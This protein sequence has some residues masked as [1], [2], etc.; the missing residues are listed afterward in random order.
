MGAVLT[1]S[2]LGLEKALDLPHAATLCGACSVACPVKIPLPD[3]LR[4]LREKQVDLGLRPGKERRGIR[5]WS[6][7]ARRPRLYAL[8]TAIGAVFLR[9][10]GGGD[11]LIGR[12]PF[13][14]EWTRQRFFPAP[15]SWRTFRALYAARR[16]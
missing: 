15:R 14:S 10:L 3:L 6:W 7:V 1:P 9:V 2:Y 13:G 16:R 5:A 12:L 11:G 4:R 8:A